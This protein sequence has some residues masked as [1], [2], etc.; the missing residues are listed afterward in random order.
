MSASAVPEG[1]C[2][3]PEEAAQAREAHQLALA[4]LSPD[5]EH[6]IA[7]GSG[8]VPQRSE[9][10][11]VLDVLGRLVQRTTHALR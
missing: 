7:E 1:R 5:T 11:L 6:V 10:Q 8:H 3:V 9:P 2:H 4:R